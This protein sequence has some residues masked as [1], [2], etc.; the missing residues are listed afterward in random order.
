M[1]ALPPSVDLLQLLRT[2]CT[3]AA[4]RGS[5]RVHVEDLARAFTSNGGSDASNTLFSK[6]VQSVLTRAQERALTRVARCV[7]RADLF[8][9]LLEH[10]TGEELLSIDARP[11]LGEEPPPMKD[12][13][14]VT[15]QHHMGFTSRM[16]VRPRDPENGSRR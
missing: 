4:Q 6:E 15:V 7:E 14:T 2:A 16:V 5:E 3:L 9:A 11:P 1:S 8:D 10:R 13:D 12:V